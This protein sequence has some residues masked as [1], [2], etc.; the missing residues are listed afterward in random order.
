MRTSMKVTLAA[1]GAAIAS[2]PVMAQ[3]VRNGYVQP[4]LSTDNVFW[5]VPYPAYGR[6][7]APAY[8]HPAYAQPYGYGSAG[9]PAAGRSNEYT[10]ADRRP[11]VDCVHVTFPSCS[12]GG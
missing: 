10:P 8:G 11:I 6:P 4:D 5:G 3:T 12:G 7:P 1:I 2:Y 9:R